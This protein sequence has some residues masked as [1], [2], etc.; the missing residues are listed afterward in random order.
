M[1]D[2]KGTNYFVIVEFK[3]GISK[4]DYLLDIST[5]TIKNSFNLTEEVHNSSAPGDWVRFG[6]MLGNQKDFLGVGGDPSWIQGYGY[7]FDLTNG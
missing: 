7:W 2:L 3:T 1:K 5:P 6:D 4:V